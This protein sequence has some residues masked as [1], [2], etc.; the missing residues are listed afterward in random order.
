[1]RPAILLGLE[2]VPSN[3]YHR[4]LLHWACPVGLCGALGIRAGGWDS[5]WVLCLDTASSLG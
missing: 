1:M 5:L 3:V 2:R 4:D